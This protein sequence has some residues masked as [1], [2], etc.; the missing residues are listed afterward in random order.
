MV[1]NKYKLSFTAASL[2]ISESIKIAEVYLSCKDWEKT[3][4][5]VVENNLL[6]SRTNSRTIRVLRE[7]IQRLKL[8]SD[9][10][11]YLLVEGDLQEQRYLL[12]FAICKTY[13][14]IREFAIEVLREKF[15]S[16]FLEI[17]DLDYDAFFNRKADWNEELDS[18]TTTT[19]DKLKQVVFRMLK[20]TGLISNRNIIIQAI[21]SNRLMDALRTDAPMSYEVFPIQPSDIKG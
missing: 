11:I 13:D 19:K 12:W 21:L 1:V 16:L 3:K 8:L 18:I 14:F 9:E 10:Q 7:L 17:S 6:Q 5:I 20:E 2:S 4:D 15:L